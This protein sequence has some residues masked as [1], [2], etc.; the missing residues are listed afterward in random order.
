MRRQ[1]INLDQLIHKYRN[2]TKICITSVISYNISF[3]YPQFADCD[4]L[5]HM[6]VQNSVFDWVYWNKPDVNLYLGG[7]YWRVFL[8]EI[9]QKDPI[10]NHQ[11][12]AVGSICRMLRRNLGQELHMVRFFFFFFYCFNQ[13]THRKG[14]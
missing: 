11:C 8:W 7:P 10:Q 3:N 12:R 9:G 13:K 2:V 1:G 4:L 5:V 6:M 14:K